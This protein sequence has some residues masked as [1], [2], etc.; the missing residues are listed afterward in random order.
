MP[1]ILLNDSISL[2]SFSY[3]GRPR[4]H[5]QRFL[6]SKL[7]KDVSV[8]LNNLAKGTELECLECFVPKPMFSPQLHRAPPALPC[9]WYTPGDNHEHS[10]NG[11]VAL[12]VCGKDSRVACSWRSKSKEEREQHLEATKA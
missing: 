9:H 6:F 4:R 2:I 10:G 1:S 11:T 3:H 5:I 7:A 12:R 8:K